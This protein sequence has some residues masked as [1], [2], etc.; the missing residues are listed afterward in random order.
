MT[1]YWLAYVMEKHS[2]C[3]TFFLESAP[4]LPDGAF[5]LLDGFAV[6]FMVVWDTRPAAVYLQ[7]IILEVTSL[8]L[9]PVR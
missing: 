2:E 8:P 9:R 1:K 3:I 6:C 4:L 7:E 5:R